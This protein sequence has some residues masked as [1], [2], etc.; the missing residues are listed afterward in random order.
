MYCYSVA[1]L[2]W[3]IILGESTGFLVGSGD[4]KFCLYSFKSS[5]LSLEPSLPAPMSFPIPHPRNLYLKILFLITFFVVTSSN[6]S[7]IANCI[8]IFQTTLTVSQWPFLPS[9]QPIPTP[10]HSPS[11]FSKPPEWLFRS[12]S[13]ISLSGSNIFL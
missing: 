9:V 6:F 4:P 8:S 11:I 2:T 10:T 3:V 5:L 1:Q 7:V 13:H 12:L